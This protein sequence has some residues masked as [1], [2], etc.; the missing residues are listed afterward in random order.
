[1]EPDR[2]IATI[3]EPTERTSNM[4]AMVE[5]DKVTICLDPVDLSKALLW[6]HYPMAT[7]GRYHVTPG[8]GE[9]CTSQ[10]IIGLLANSA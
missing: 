5:K 8:R 6:E 3:M 1:M 4:V 7:L 9:V 2:A 10:C